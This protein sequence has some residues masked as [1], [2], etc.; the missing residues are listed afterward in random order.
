MAVLISCGLSIAVPNKCL[1]LFGCAPQFLQV[2]TNVSNVQD[3]GHKI[4]VS[5]NAR[6]N[7]KNDLHGNA[8]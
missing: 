6:E 4:V 7:D 1:A 2:Q 5:A 3:P 8:F